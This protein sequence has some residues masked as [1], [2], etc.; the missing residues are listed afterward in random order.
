MIWSSQSIHPP[1]GLYALWPVRPL[2]EQYEY[3]LGTQAYRKE[4]P[5]PVREK[6]SNDFTAEPEAKE[7]EWVFLYN[8][9]DEPE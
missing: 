2:A 6:F 1:V 9:D 7:D 3:L 4:Q 5:D 8:A